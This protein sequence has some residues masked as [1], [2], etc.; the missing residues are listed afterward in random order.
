MKTLKP[1]DKIGFEFLPCHSSPL[2]LITNIRAALVKYQLKQNNSHQFI[3]LDLHNQAVG[4]RG[5][6]RP[7]GAKKRLH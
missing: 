7:K 5:A 4:G 2:A 1:S 3:L 6:G